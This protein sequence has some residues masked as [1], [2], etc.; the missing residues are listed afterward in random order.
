MAQNHQEYLAWTYFAEDAFDRAEFARLRETLSGVTRF[1][2]VGAS[3]GVYTF[4]ANQILDGAEIFAIEADPERFQVLSANV[5]KWSEG[6]TNTIHCINA[7]ASD[8]EDRATSPEMTFFT[9]GTQISGGLFK[10]AERS[11]AYAPTVVP[12]VCVDDYFD[13]RHQT[14]VKIDVEGAEL[15][16][17]RGAERHIAAG[18]TK[19]FTEVS[20]WGD[21]DRKTNFLDLLRFCFRSGLRID[22]RLRSDYLMAPEPRPFARLASIVRCVPPLLLRA[23]YNTMVPANVRT[24]RERLENRRRVARFEGSAHP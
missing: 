23:I 1:I 10:V 19:F 5:A 9:T 20:W 24:R 22:R 6:S 17:L 7:A 2:D 18:N 15:R 3:H 8:E 13:A 16:V 11:D 4:H 12:L 21:R 14:F